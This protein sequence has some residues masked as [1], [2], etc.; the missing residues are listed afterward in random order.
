MISNHEAEC[1]D[2]SC[3]LDKSI[4]DKLSNFTA[5]NAR[6]RMPSLETNGALNVSEV[7]FLF[8]DML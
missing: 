8:N 7:E 1:H 4:R 2:P 3:L 6:F 5:Y